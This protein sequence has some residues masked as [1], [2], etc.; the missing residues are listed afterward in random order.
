ML[1]RL[2]L[3]LLLASV[4]APAQAR[5]DQV[6]YMKNGVYAGKIGT[7]SLDGESYL[8]A[9][10]TARLV[11]GK[12]YLYPV[13]GKLLMQIKGKRVL[14]SMKSDTIRINDEDV[15]FPDPM[16][17]RGGRA[18]LALKFFVSNHFSDA[19]GFSL[20]YDKSSRVL[21]ARHAVNVTSVNY[22][23]YPDK[24]R[25]VVYME[26]PLQWQATQKENNL[27]RVN[28]F[29]GIIDHEEKLAI[30]DG[31]VRGV[32]LLQD[33]KT[34]RLVVAPDDNFGEAKVFAITGP[35]RL[36]IDVSKKASPVRQTISG[37]PGA[38]VAPA[39]GAVPP[40]GTDPAAPAD[41]RS[42]PQADT[43]T[44]AVIL[45]SSAAPVPAGAQPAASDASA[46]NLPDKLQVGASGR[47]RIVIDAG[48]GGKD[49]GGNRL[50]GMREKDINLAVAKDL[51]KLLKKDPKFE[52]M[53][54][55]DDDT[56]VPLSDR[57]NMANNFKA[58]LFISLHANASRDRREKG[59]EVYFMSEKASDPGAAE[60][61][62]YENSVVGLED[63]GGQSENDAAAMLL[64][65]MAR[66]EYLNEGSQLAGLVS[67]EMEKHTP[68]VDRGVKQ[69]A[70]Y[71]LRGTYAPGI[72][73]EMGFMTNSRDQRD[74]NKK[75]VRAEIADSIYRG[76]TD[77]AKMKKW[78]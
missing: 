64:H 75:K 33:N 4:C 51:Y 52:V 14:F 30:G 37:D 62:D 25:I 9:G 36:V 23:S 41:D 6:T 21:S 3:L 67:K 16:I 50:F 11:G 76:I 34:A 73:V 2:S 70:F 69:A 20:S 32:D 68:F 7:Y 45:P 71:V 43:R 44:A 17:V 59:F 24:T 35:D 8:D 19:F 10:Q 31:V 56:F 29:G 42:A 63:N 57:S 26:E 65:S 27:F 55:R 72:L 39:S 38:F 15:N 12:I 28:I 13:S 49:A 61:A 66:N 18:F 40:G 1:K 53:M 54:T 78:E 48:H 46:L 22:F 74:L 47:K 5:V 60:V 58:D 77:Y